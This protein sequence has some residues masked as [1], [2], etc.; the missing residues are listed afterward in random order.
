MEACIFASS[1]VSSF[2]HCCKCN[3]LGCTAAIRRGRACHGPQS[4]SVYWGSEHN[5]FD[6]LRPVKHEAGFPNPRRLLIGSNHDA[7]MTHH[8]YILPRIRSMPVMPLVNRKHAMMCKNRAGIGPMTTQFWHIGKVNS[9][10]TRT[11]F[12]FSITCVNSPNCEGKSLM[13]LFFNNN[14]TTHFSRPIALGTLFNFLL[15]KFK[16]L[17]CDFNAGKSSVSA[18]VV[19]TQAL[20][21]PRDRRQGV[22]GA[23]DHSSTHFGTLESS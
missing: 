3:S 22:R 12:R 19:A 4:F 15:H 5:Q 16:T 18:I 1:T 20:V 11:N 6:S 13:L 2:H 21:L 7:L 9:G 14:W 8:T 17:G 23:P 10:H